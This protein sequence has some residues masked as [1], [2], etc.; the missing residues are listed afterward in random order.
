MC[1]RVRERERCRTPRGC[2]V[3]NAVAKHSGALVPDKR[4]RREHNKR[5]G[6]RKT[7]SDRRDAY[8]DVGVVKKT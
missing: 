6:A 2:I 4:E 7:A 3:A 1:V 5:R 8:T